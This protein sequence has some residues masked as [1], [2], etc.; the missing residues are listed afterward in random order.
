MLLPVEQGKA[1]GNGRE[2]MASLKWEG[3]CD[4]QEA[5]GDEGRW[6]VG[7]RE[8]DLQREELGRG[9]GG[10]GGRACQ[11]RGQGP[12]GL[13]SKLTFPRLLSFLPRPE[14]KYLSS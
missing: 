7:F 1:G 12:L 3:L 5:Q 2:A 11:R 10:V 14:G 13:H 4:L 6:K 9:G 8:E